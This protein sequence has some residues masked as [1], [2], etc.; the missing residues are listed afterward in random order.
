M[1]YKPRAKDEPRFSY[2]I[3]REHKANIDDRI[4]ALAKKINK[5]GEYQVISQNAIFLEI[6]YRGLDYLER[7]D[8]TPDHDEGW[9]E[10]EF[11]PKKR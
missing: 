6:V 3:A 1:A 5:S 4:R 2:R 9:Y 7:I 8:L 11:N 10:V